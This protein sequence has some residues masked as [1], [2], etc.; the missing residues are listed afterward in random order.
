MLAGIT[1]KPLQYQEYGRGFF[2][3]FCRERTEMKKVYL[4]KKDV[5]K[6]N[7]A[8]NWIE[9]NGYEQAPGAVQKKLVDEYQAAR[10]AN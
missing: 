3:R 2:Y 5:N 6:P 7:G 9:L 8:D 1:R 10:A 4:V